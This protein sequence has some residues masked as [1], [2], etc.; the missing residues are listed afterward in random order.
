[1]FRVNVLNNLS[2]VT[3]KLEMIGI[4]VQER[5]FES[6]LASESEIKNLFNAQYFD[7]T[8][9]EINSESDGVSISIKSIEI[10]P[11]AY[12]NDTGFEYASISQKVKDI[13][14]KKINS[15]S[16]S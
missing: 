1:M 16:G 2:K 15:K 4:N 9:I 10:N 11:G 5:V 14:M 12:E 3:N 13:I 8:Q 6:I 7:S